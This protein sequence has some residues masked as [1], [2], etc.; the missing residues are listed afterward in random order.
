[1]PNVVSLRLE[2]LE[3]GENVRQGELDVTDLVESIRLHGLLQNLVVKPNGADKFRVIAGHRRLEALR[4]VYEPMDEVDCLVFGA[5]TDEQAIGLI[6]NTVRA[7]MHPLDIAEAIFALELKKLSDE[8]IRAQLGLSQ[9]KL[10][11]W[12]KLALLIDEAKQ[13]YR[14]GKLDYSQCA[15]L[16]MGTAKQQ[17][18][19]LK[20]MKRYHEPYGADSV[21]R[22]IFGK[23]ILAGRANAFT[24]EEY[25]AAGG[26]MTT[27]L[28][29][30]PTDA[31]EG[32]GYFD[33]EALYLKL[34]KQKAEERGQMLKDAGWKEAKVVHGKEAEWNGWYG[35]F[36]QAADQLRPL[37]R[38][39][40]PGE[41]ALLQQIME[42]QGDTPEE[43]ERKDDLKRELRALR[44]KGGDAKPVYTDEQKRNG[45]AVV[46]LGGA[47][48][49]YPIEIEFYE[50]PD[51]VKAKVEAKAAKAKKSKPTK[52]ELAAGKIGV[53]KTVDPLSR[54]RLTHRARMDAVQALATAIAV[55]IAG[56]GEAVQLRLGIFGFATGQIKLN[57]DNRQITAAVG[58]ADPQV[59]ELMGPFAKAIG[60][61]PTM[62]DLAPMWQYEM[63]KKAVPILERCM[64][65]SDG[66]V[67]AF[68]R[69]LSIA[70]IKDFAGPDNLRQEPLVKVGQLV[71]VKPHNIVE[72]LPVHVVESMTKA[73]L[74]EIVKD[75]I[76]EGWDK[77]LASAK[78]KDLGHLVAILMKD[79]SVLLKK[80][81]P[82]TNRTVSQMDVEHMIGNVVKA[83]LAGWLPP[84]LRS[85]MKELVPTKEAE[86]KE[87]PPVPVVATKTKRSKDAPKAGRRGKR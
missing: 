87:A 12:R 80:D 77:T 62:S 67:S 27:D 57:L 44:K 52:A 20:D 51:I 39:P 40:L 55:R 8:A 32:I 9:I 66:E 65:L 24:V 1:M 63:E 2:E 85:A 28:F 34:Q 60:A 35:R 75:L 16:A 47:Y 79:A 81:F 64:A 26:K 48:E 23:K 72:K 42:L 49:G 84:S 41:E 61:S 58:A 71:G 59:L 68:Y 19:V 70:A 82:S 14:E 10:D 78:V 21:R 69:A 86:P 7:A 73:E 37:A 3:H 74:L 30:V 11:R 38:E 5:E 17:R 31:T 53:D 22:M 33:D 76:G 29:F 45:I 54:D 15:A 6:E 4:Q 18:E 43:K 50:H 13:L 46:K 36:R 56:A 83:K 25:L